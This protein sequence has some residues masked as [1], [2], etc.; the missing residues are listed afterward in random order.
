L[1]P[2]RDAVVAAH[3][4]VEQVV[5]ILILSFQERLIKTGKAG[6]QKGRSAAL[7]ADKQLEVGLT[8]K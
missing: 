6:E 3:E 4:G 8:E 1:D 7:P 5:R 2:V